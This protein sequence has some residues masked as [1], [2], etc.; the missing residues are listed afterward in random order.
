MHFRGFVVAND[1]T[2]DEVFDS[3]TDEQIDV[4]DRVSLQ[5][6]AATLRHL[7]TAYRHLGCFDDAIRCFIHC[8]QAS[9]TCYGSHSLEVAEALGELG[10]LYYENKEYAKFIQVCQQI[11]HIQKTA[12]GARK[13]I[14]DDAKL[15][16]R[17][18]RSLMDIGGAAEEIRNHLIMAV[19]VIDDAI[20][21]EAEGACGME[22]SRK[23]CNELLLECLTMILQ[24]SLVTD[25]EEM[26]AQD[27]QYLAD[28]KHRMGAL[29][30][31]M[32]QFDAAIKTFSELLDAQ[33]ESDD[34]DRLKIADLLFNLGNV[35]LETGDL[36]KARKCH[37]ES[38]GIY[39]LIVGDDSGEIADNMACMGNVE[40]RCGKNMAALEWYDRALFIL[41][42]CRA[43]DVATIG[44]LV[45][46]KVNFS[47]FVWFVF[48]PRFVD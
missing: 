33:W 9:R 34:G 46:R 39:A 13:P 16:M 1:L 12:L 2:S 48:R 44:K 28:V 8:V 43:D 24:T 30:A 32:R 47:F 40:F 3:L 35:Y 25:D 5:E 7:A 17:Y 41:Q 19:D 18:G 26:D 45:F 4:L 11:F 36:E 14:I 21:M 10:H 27:D 15:H 23:D 20:H 38:H 29:Q 22:V 31:D 37:E 6:T 42:N